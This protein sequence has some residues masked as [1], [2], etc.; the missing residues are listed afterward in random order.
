MPSKGLDPRRASTAR[1]LLLGFVAA[2]VVAGGT[3]LLFR[4]AAEQVSGNVQTTG[5]AVGSFTFR[6]DDCA[7]GHAFVPGFFGANLRGGARYDL[8]LVGSGDDAQLWIFPPGAA[9][10]AIPFGKADAP[11]GTCAMTGPT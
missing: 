6:V 5:T 1:V 8:R 9:R 2:A 7:S 4:R 10:G 3:L 11:P